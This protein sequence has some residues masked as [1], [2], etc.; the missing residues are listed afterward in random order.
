MTEKGIDA[1]RISVATGTTDARRG[2][3]PGARRRDFAADVQGTTPVN[4][5]DGEGAAA[6]G[7][8]PV[9][10]KKAAAAKK[11]AQSAYSRDGLIGAHNTTS[12]AP[13]AW[14]GGAGQLAV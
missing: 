1:S 11:A 2:R 9:A 4:E 7:P 5:T 6:Q 8:H 12:P 3:L 10:H 13:P 14:N